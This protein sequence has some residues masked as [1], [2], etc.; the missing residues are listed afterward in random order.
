MNREKTVEIN[1][2]E[3]RKISH[4][5][6]C[7]SADDA[8]C[9]EYEEPSATS[10]AIL[11]DASIEIKQKTI[12]RSDIVEFNDIR[13]DSSYHDETSN[14]LLESSCLNFV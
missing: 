8:I 5:G 13:T 4:V 7:C 10:V 2:I 11:T 1:E 9:S 14:I 12:D 6:I 3:Q